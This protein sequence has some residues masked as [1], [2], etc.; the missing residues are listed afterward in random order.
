MEL[1]KTIKDSDIGSAIEAPNSFKERHASRAVVFDKENNVALFH[2]TKKQYHKLPGGGVEKGEDLEAALRRELLEEIGCAVKNIRPIGVI[3]EYRNKF[4]L[5]Q[6]SHCFIAE[7]D[8]EKG[9]PH[10]EEGEI[11]EGFVTEWMNIEVAI[12]TVESE[13]AVEDY[14]G[15]F[16]QMRDLCF[17]QE[18]QRLARAYRK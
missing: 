6:F 13:R 14:Q 11:A 10:L 4:G 8:G 18:A 17:L 16:I 5:H 15:K 1:L 9:K 7:V 3:E 12:R 2:A